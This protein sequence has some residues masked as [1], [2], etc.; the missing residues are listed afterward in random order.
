[1]TND[2][3][4]DAYI[5]ILNEELMPA[6]G[7]TEPIAIAYAAAVARRT[8][9]SFPETLDVFCSGNIVKNAKGVTVPQTGDLRGIRAAATVGAFAGNADR[10]LEVL[11]CV[12]AAD[13]EKVRQLLD[14]GYAAEHLE[15]ADC[16]LYIRV[17]AAGNGHLAEV[18]LKEHHTNITSVKYDGKEQLS[19]TTA[20]E[21]I[22]PTEQTD[23]SVLN[24]DGIFDF[25][26]H[27]PV[28]EVKDI[29][30]RQIAYNMAIA[31]EGIRNEYGACVGRTILRHGKEADPET[32]ARAYAAAGSDARMSG[33]VLPVVINSG[34]GNQGIVVS[35]PVYVMAKERGA[36]DETMYRALLLSNLISIY[37]K[38]MIGALSA[39]CG[40][41]SA[42]AGT[43][44]GVAYLTGAN[45]A[46]IEK[47]IINILG[48]V[49]GMIC[50]GAK[51]S[52]AAK[53][54][55]ALDTAFT[56]CDMAEDGKAF[57]SGEGIIMDDTEDTMRAV[58]RLGGKGMSGTD[59]EIL[60]IMTGE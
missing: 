32:V 36:D 34:S 57:G 22:T 31:E 42:A 37:Q 28:T 17:A 4:Y 25:C 1:M 44:A 48:C 7:C 19:A 55:T 11:T 40:A 45:R 33:C 15:E 5:A 43:G 50:D 10:K 56:A 60:R 53:I 9:G 27:V 14:S 3:L 49:S 6:L 39:Y 13:V 29:L 16:S 30:D 20:C 41:V 21:E 54:A 18:E 58:G 26:E 38:S 8:L 52:C 47:T 2:P 46:Q 24:L 12:T 59:R 51:P 23:R 35:V